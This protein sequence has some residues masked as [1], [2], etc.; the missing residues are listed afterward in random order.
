MNSSV[1]IK[2]V[3]G[4]LNS[5]NGIIAMSIL[6]ALGLAA[7]C[8]SICEGRSCYNVKPYQMSNILKNNF[9]H[10]GKCYKYQPYQHNCP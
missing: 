9:K 3:L 7:M 10:D 6:W 4:F 1:R 8:R 2:K 5:N